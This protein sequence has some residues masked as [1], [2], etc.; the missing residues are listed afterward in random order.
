MSI[1]EMEAEL[2][3]TR[4]KIAEQLSLVGKSIQS[5]DPTL[6]DKERIL[7]QA[8]I[9]G[10]LDEP[11]KDYM[12][13]KACL[14]A[15]LQDQLEALGQ[16]QPM[17][18]NKWRGILQELAQRCPPDRWA[19]DAQEG[20]DPDTFECGYC[21]ALMQL[22]AMSMRE[23]H[24]IPIDEFPIPYIVEAR[25]REAI[26]H[27]QIE[28]SNNVELLTPPVTRFF[29][30]G[31]EHTLIQEQSNE[32]I[33]AFIERKILVEPI[34]PIDTPYFDLADLIARHEGDKE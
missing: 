5:I 21:C 4:Q 27:L 19:E 7:E 10:Y 3:A 12:H 8:V 31:V 29:R 26:L 24:C 23:G 2:E 9:D 30:D 22:H 17:S 6:Y 1:K 28:D 11:A 34:P 32:E 25:K 15:A 33:D 14:D 18:S 16:D 20:P 13:A